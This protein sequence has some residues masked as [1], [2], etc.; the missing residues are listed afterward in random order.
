MF[1]GRIWI[2]WKG[3][4]KDSFIVCVPAIG[5]LHNK[6]NYSTSL[7]LVFPSPLHICKF[8]ISISKNDGLPQ[9]LWVNAFEQDKNNS[10]LGDENKLVH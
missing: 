8:I 4:N 3:E 2:S 7:P 5:A 10:T 1:S 9:Y 6:V